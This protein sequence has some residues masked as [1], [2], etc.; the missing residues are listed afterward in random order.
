MR[1]WLRRQWLPLT[2]AV[3][4][5]AGAMAYS[6]VL[7]WVPYQQ[8]LPTQPQTVAAGQRVDYA[9]GSFTLT[10]AKV[11][12][13]GTSDGDDLEL[14]PGD[15]LIVATLEVTPGPR[16]SSGAFSCDLTL[17]APSAAG[18]RHW[19]LSLFDGSSYHIPDGME[20]SCLTTESTPF[21]TQAVFVVPAGTAASGAQVQVDVS[22]QR[23]R[24]LRM[25]LPA[26]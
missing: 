3:V 1:G 19:D 26:N 6:L 24:V 15:E 10:D 13:G 2:L 7:N 22:G 21:T 17:V 12:E 4:L 18:E 25:S 16:N 8:A 9:G 11:V 14:R 5:F 23:P 20:L